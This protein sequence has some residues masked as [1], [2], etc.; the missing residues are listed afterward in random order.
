MNDHTKRLMLMHSNPSTMLQVYIVCERLRQAQLS[1]N[2]ALGA[3]AIS[4]LV[5][6]IGA[7][8]LLSGQLSEGTVTAAIGI[9]SSVCCSRMA[10]DANDRL[11]RLW[12]RG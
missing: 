11:D 6:L 10:K 5:G 1:F 9:T 7:G 2:L 12:L 8:L 4:A 3:S